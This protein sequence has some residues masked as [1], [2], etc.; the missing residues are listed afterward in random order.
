MLGVCTE[1]NGPAIL[2]F[3]QVASL[4]QA[5]QFTFD[6]IGRSRKFLRK[7]PE[8]ATDLRVEKSL[9]NSLI[10]VFDVKSSVNMENLYK[11]MNEKS[12]RNCFGCERP[13]SLDRLAKSNACPAGRW[14]GDA[15]P[16]AF[17]EGAVLLAARV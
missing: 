13:C 15:R 3:Y 9:I 7:F 17:S 14:C 10:R 5:V 2:L 6:C 12:T 11:K 1:I 8:V 4:C 16:E